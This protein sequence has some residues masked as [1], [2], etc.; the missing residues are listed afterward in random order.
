MLQREIEMMTLSSSIFAQLLPGT[1][2]QLLVEHCLNL[3]Q[4][5]LVGKSILTNFRPNRVVADMDG[6][7][8]FD[9]GGSLG[10]SINYS[11]FLDIF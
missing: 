9:L 1:P 6:N 4:E 2:E 10:F 7:G 3:L 8:E 5:N 11:G